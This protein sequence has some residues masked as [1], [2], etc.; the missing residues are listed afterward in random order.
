MAARWRAKSC[1]FTTIPWLFLL[2]EEGVTVPLG[3][4]LTTKLPSTDGIVSLSTV[5][6]SFLPSSVDIKE[7]I[8]TSNMIDRG[9]KRAI[10]KAKKISDSE[11]IRLGYS[12][13]F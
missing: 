8:I 4:A 3:R 9:L 6:N 2:G 11:R 1:S 10:E 5:F 7:A 13:S 12:W